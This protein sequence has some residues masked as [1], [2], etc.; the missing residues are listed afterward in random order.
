MIRTIAATPMTS[1]QS[2]SSGTAEM[3]C[4][5][6]DAVDTGDG[7]HVVDEQRAGDDERAEHRQV[8]ARDGVVA[9]ARRVGVDDLAVA[10][11]DRPPGAGRSPAA[12]GRLRNSAPAPARTRTRR[13]SSVAYAEEL[14]GSELKIASALVFDRRSRDLLVDRQRPAEQDAADPREERGPPASAA[15]TPPPWRRACPRACTGSTPRAAARCGP[16][17]RRASDP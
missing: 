3:T 5:A 2:C 15:P 1:F 6:A 17:G 8:A 12:T 4:S 9:A 14:I 16:A 11:R 13:I 7:H 10:D